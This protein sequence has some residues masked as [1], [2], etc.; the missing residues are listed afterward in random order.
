MPVFLVHTYVCYRSTI[1]TDGSKSSGED[2]EI[3]EGTLLW[4]NLPGV[5]NS[6]ILSTI[7]PRERKRQEVRRCILHGK[8]IYVSIS[9]CVDPV[10]IRYVW[11]QWDC[12]E[13]IHLS[14]PYDVSRRCDTGMQ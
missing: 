12:W 9:G 2:S 11:D 6:G 1:V 4:S 7:S 8:G 13:H 5:R 3:L 10:A 14:V